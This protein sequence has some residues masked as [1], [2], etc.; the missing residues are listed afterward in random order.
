MEKRYC[1]V[2]KGEIELNKYWTKGSGKYYS[3]NRK[4]ILECTRDVDGCAEWIIK[5]ALLMLRE[6][7]NEFCY[8]C[9]LKIRNACCDLQSE[10]LTPIKATIN[11]LRGK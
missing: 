11:E 6:W 1:D 2:C 9:A 8:N 3:H 7:E 5:G 10:L 4:W